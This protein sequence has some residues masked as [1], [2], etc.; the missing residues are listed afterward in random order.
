MLPDWLA[1][2]TFGEANG[3][4]SLAELRGRLRDLQGGARIAPDPLGQITCLLIAE[5]RF[6]APGDWIA[7]PAD[8][9][10][11]T[12]SGAGYDLDVGEGRRIWEACVARGATEIG[13][14]DDGARSAPDDRAPRC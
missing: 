5:A 13:A 14:D 8:W 4:G 11:R 7:A 1:W 10:V 12:V 9:K 3:V 6:F 2:D